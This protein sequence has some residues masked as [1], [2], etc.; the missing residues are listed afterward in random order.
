MGVRDV[1][2]KLRAERLHADGYVAR[3]ERLENLEAEAREQERVAQYVTDLR[4]ERASVEAHLA[5]LRRMP[6][7]AKVAEPL[8]LT[9]GVVLE[10]RDPPT[11]ASLIS[12]NEARVEAIDRELERVGG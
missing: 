3:E 5:R 9:D 4:R 7:D 10:P 6:P 8:A 11:A 2:Y 12:S 1:I